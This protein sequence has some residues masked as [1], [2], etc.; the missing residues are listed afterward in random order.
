MGPAWQGA[1]QGVRCILWIAVALV[2]AGCSREAT[3]TPLSKELAGPDEPPRA[4]PMGVKRYPG[5]RDESN[6]APAELPK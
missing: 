1:R 5:A 2:A 4:A 3:F 6:S